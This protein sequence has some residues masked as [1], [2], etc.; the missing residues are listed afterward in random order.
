MEDVRQHLIDHLPI[1][2]HG[3]NIKPSSTLRLL[4]VHTDEV[5]SFEAHNGNIVEYVLLSPELTQGYAEMYTSRNCKNI[6]ECGCGH[7]VRLL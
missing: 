1:I 3:I 5:M 7:E 2:G 6:S 4:Q